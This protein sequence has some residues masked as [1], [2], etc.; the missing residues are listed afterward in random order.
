MKHIWK[1]LKIVFK[2][3]IRLNLKRSIWLSDDVIYTNLL[4]DRDSDWLF[5]LTIT[6]RTTKKRFFIIYNT[7]VEKFGLISI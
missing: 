5:F 2:F 7:K 4:F 6:N 3:K 1:I